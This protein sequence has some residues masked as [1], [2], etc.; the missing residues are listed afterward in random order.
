MWWSCR[1]KVILLLHSKLKA[2]LEQEIWYAAEEAV[3]ENFL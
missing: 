2:L 1:T 3:F